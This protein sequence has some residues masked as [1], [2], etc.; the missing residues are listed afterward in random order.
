MKKILFV[1]LF[2]FSI[3]FI[4]TFVMA[5]GLSTDFFDNVVIKAN[6]INTKSKK[7]IINEYCK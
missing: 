2:L 3:L 7:N 4:G 6:G 1:F 5:D